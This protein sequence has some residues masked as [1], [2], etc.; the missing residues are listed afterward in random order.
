MGFCN[1][2][3]HPRRRPLLPPR[4]HQL[5]LLQPRRPPNLSSPR[6]GPAKPPR[7]RHSRPR[8]PLSEVCMTRDSAR[9]A[10]AYSSDAPRSFTFPVSPSTHVGVLPTGP[11]LISSRV[12]DGLINT[13]NSTS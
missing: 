13:E 9:S 5:L 8:N 7:I 10:H 11:S 12:L 1:Q 2:T 4:R 3:W 6:M